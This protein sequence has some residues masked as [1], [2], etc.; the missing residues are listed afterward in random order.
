MKV[1]AIISL[2]AFVSCAHNRG[3][4][5]VNGNPVA[6]DNMAGG[7]VK[8]SAVKTIDQ[9]DVCFD[10]S[11]EMKGVDQKEAMASNWTLAW[12]DKDSRYHLLSLNQRDP[13]SVPKGGTKVA[14]YGA[15]EEWSNSFKACAPK[16]RIGDVKSLVL[17]PKELSYKETEGMKLEWN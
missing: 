5:S 8:A 16:A 14:P 6:Y 17:T 13:A 15:Y 7:N 11:L 3:P 12:V 9:Q 2:F 4:A 10:I 1:L